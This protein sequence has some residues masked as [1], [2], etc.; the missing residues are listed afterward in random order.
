MVRKVRRR[1]EDFA[2]KTAHT[3]ATGFEMV[4][5]EAL[6][7]KNMTTGVKPKPDPERPGAFLPNRGRRQG[8]T[9]PIH[10]G[11]GLVSDRAGHPW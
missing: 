2:A 8:R 4:V 3:L 9:E 10:L 6:K 7:T 11:Q 5:F 1:R